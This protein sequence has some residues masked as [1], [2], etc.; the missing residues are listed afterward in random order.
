VAARQQFAELGYDRTSVRAVAQ[1]AGVAPRL[2]T[3]FFG[4]KQ[5]LFVT[6]VE[7]PFR[8]A[9]VLPALV[10]GDRDRLGER[11]AGF[12]LTAFSV[13]QA[14]H[15]VIG[16]IRAAATE[17]EAARLVRD[18]LTRE[19]FGPLAEAI[20]ADRPDLR[21]TLVGSQVVGMVMARYIV[22]VEPLASTDA[23]VIAAAI[24]PVLQHYLT[25]PLGAG[26]AER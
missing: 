24:A 7:L 20:G 10:A 11:L 9:D 15:R 2:I 6:V 22:A 16:L 17:P 8:P 14:R 26:G 13:D 25:G 5:A 12:V 23:S 3:H 21:A 18:L 19:I 4:S 1:A